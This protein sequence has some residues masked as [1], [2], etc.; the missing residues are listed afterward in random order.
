MTPFPAKIQIQS[1]VCSGS[2]RLDSVR[3]IFS[4]YTVHEGR[5]DPKPTHDLSGLNQMPS[6]TD[7]GGRAGAGVGAGVAAPM[8]M[9][10]VYTVTFVPSC[11]GKAETWGL[12]P[13]SQPTSFY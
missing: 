5:P 10:I 11:W 8:N 12:L 2:L 6:T 3:L 13:G 7:P 1:Y 4:K 9:T